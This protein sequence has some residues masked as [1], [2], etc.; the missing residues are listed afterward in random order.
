MS[1]D[2][3]TRIVTENQ[4][5][6]ST[7]TPNDDA[8]V[9]TNQSVQSAA[10][11]H[12]DET[13]IT[14]QSPITAS[15]GDVP[16]QP[17]PQKKTLIKNRFELKKMLGA[18]GMGAV[19]QAVDL[20]KVEAKD[21]NPYVAVKLLND[22]FKRHPDAFISLQRESRK[23]QNLAHPNIVTVYDFDRDSDMVFMTMEFME[24]AP[25]DEIIRQCAGVGLDQEEAYSV[26][27]DVS[28]ALAYA[29]SQG[30]IHSDFKPGNIFFT[31]NKTAK[32]FDFGIARAVSSTGISSGSTDDKT[33]FDAGSLSALTPTYASYEM[34]KGEE[35]SP[36]DDVYALACVTYELFAGKHPYD[37]TPADQAFD[38]KLKPERIKRL[39]KR[40]WKA[41]AKALQLKGDQRTQTV[42]AFKAAFFSKSKLPYYIGGGTIAASVIAGLVYQQTHLV[43]ETQLRESLQDEIQEELQVNIRANVELEMNQRLSLER[44]N[45]AISEPLS[46]TWSE[47]V[48][49]LIGEYMA[50]APGD[51]DSIVGARQKA[52]SVF[53]DAAS[54]ARSD[55]KLSEAKR[56]LD[57]AGLWQNESDLLEQEASLLANAE[58]ALLKR[59]EEQRLAAQA[60]AERLAEARKQEQLRLEKERKAREQRLAREA[61]QRKINAAVA[62]VKDSLSCNARID[63]K[64]DLTSKVNQLQKVSKARYNKEQAG[65]VNSLGSCIKTVARH[66]PASAR[67]I[68]ADSLALFPKSASLSAISI[69]MCAH[70]RPGSGSKGRRYFCQDYLSDGGKSPVLIVAKGGSKKLA[71]S[72]YEITVGDFNNYCKK[73]GQCSPLSGDTGMPASN[74]SIAQAKAYTQWLSQQSGYSYRI[75]TKNEWM[76]VSNAE[77]NGADPDRNCYIKFGSLQKGKS[78]VKATTGKPNDNGLINYV[79][80]VQEWAF[81]GNGQLLAMGGSRKDPLKRCLVTSKVNHSGQPDDVTGFRVV[82]SLN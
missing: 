20:R 79:G 66:S 3:K 76:S 55:G 19:Y 81:D 57:E 14:G 47:K 74:I 43:D 53:L 22:D 2:D 5:H 68:K 18:G 27:K 56:L 73:T 9:L 48:N 58:E 26:F 7:P 15:Q 30:I 35:P 38:K 32:V 59:Q 10:P 28:E 65:F 6:T 52:M 24:G 75:P 77:R 41:L 70:L 71:V 61:Q 23:S 13:V 16:Q 11:G 1:A 12:Q 45:E 4:S 25:L 78:L 17:A 50:L 34:L 42:D 64:G 31:K 46:E 36:S 60:E 44:L 33:V 62:A 40:Q 54:Q 49:T 39:S 51:T 69:D 21:R 37:K 8:T 29:H 80:N 72:R 67:R 63:I 82:R